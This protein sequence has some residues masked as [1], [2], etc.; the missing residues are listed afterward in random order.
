MSDS[1]D[2]YEA[3]HSRRYQE[4]FTSCKYCG[5][6]ELIW[7]NNELDKWVLVDENEEP[8]KCKGNSMICTSVAGMNA[9]PERA[10]FLKSLMSTFT[11]GGSVPISIIIKRDYNNPYDTNAIEVILNGYKIGYVP[12][13]DQMYFDF[14]KVKE[15]SANIVSWGIIPDGAV[16]LNLNFS[17]LFIG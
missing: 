9:E 2:D 5:E 4:Q 8:H 13:R 11:N 16:Y 12:K 3:E 15:Y 1:Y 7:I 14:S 6:D 17:P 10:V